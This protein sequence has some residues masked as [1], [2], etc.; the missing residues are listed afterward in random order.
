MGHIN[1]FEYIQICHPDF[2]FKDTHVYV[3][4]MYTQKKWCILWECL[5]LFYCANEDL[6]CGKDNVISLIPV[7]SKQENCCHNYG[8]GVIFKQI[9]GYSTFSWV[10][11]NLKIILKNIKQINKKHTLHSRKWNFLGQQLFLDR[12]LLG[13]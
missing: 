6:L 5:L 3:I 13:K 9:H 12:T 10:A 7:I 11:M 8:H 4:I 1:I 2:M